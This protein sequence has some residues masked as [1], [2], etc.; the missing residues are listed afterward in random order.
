MRIEVVWSPIH[1]PFC[2]VR[3]V[4][5]PRLAGRGDGLDEALIFFECLGPPHEAG[6]NGWSRRP[7][8]P[9]PLF[10]HRSVLHSLNMGCS[11]AL[12]VENILIAGQIFVQMSCR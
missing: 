3:M 1:V 7:W 5:L 8:L 6:A 12:D 9:R 2:K 4:T 10:T 11:L